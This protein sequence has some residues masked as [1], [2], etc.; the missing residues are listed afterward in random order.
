MVLTNMDTEDKIHTVNSEP[1]SQPTDIK[2]KMF[3]KSMTD[4]DIVQKIEALKGEAASLRQLLDERARYKEENTGISKAQLNEAVN[5][6]QKSIGELSDQLDDGESSITDAI[7][8]ATSDITDKIEEKSGRDSSEKI[9]SKMN[10]SFT[11]LKISMDSASEASNSAKD[12][13]EELE[14]KVESKAEKTQIAAL[15][16]RL[17]TMFAVN[18]A[19]MIGS[20]MI[21]ALL[22]YLIVSLA[23]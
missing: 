10:S 15:H 17:T 8:K 9:L 13:A 6:L 14:E 18:I 19:G 4:E 23:R 5:E 3:D 20:I 1:N 22:S 12:K 7:K 2:T 11:E 21:L 16:Q